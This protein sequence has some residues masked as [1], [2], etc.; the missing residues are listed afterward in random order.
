[1]LIDHKLGMDGKKPCTTFFILTCP[2]TTLDIYIFRILIEGR[3]H[4]DLMVT[5][6][7]VARERGGRGKVVKGLALQP[8]R[9]HGQK[10]KSEKVE[11]LFTSYSLLS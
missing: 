1:M 10:K 8:G 2:C 3:G 5:I 6:S 11:K 9:S 4:L 7:Q